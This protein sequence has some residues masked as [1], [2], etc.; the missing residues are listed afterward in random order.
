MLSILFFVAIF[1]A[2]GYY[3]WRDRK[4]GKVAAD[5]SKLDA[6]AKAEAERLKKL[7]P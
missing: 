7:I 3:V 1:A 5:L 2:L 6:A 4:S